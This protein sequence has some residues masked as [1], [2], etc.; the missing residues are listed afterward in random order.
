MDTVIKHSFAFCWKTSSVLFS[1]LEYIEEL[2]TL[3]SKHEEVQ[4]SENISE[5]AENL[6]VKISFKKWRLT[7][8]DN[9]FE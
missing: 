7:V 5:E 6:K 2:L 9:S 8:T 3:L 1:A 4:I